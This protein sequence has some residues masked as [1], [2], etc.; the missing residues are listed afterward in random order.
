MDGTVA[1]TRIDHR[2]AVDMNPEAAP[3]GLPYLDKGQLQP[4]ELGNL[5]ISMGGLVKRA[6]QS[7]TSCEVSW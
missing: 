7:V 2:G 1:L 5:E 3:L 4:E 6:R